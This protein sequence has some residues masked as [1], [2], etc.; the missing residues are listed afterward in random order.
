MNEKMKRNLIIAAIAAG[1]LMITYISLLL[2]DVKKNHNDSLII[3]SIPSSSI[4]KLEFRGRDGKVTLIKKGNKWVYEQD[5]SFPLNENFVYSMI[6]KTSLLKA[7]R[8]V[9]EGKKQF[10]VYGLDKPSNIIQVTAGEQKKTIYL[11]DSNSAT[12]DYYLAVADSDKIYTV[13]SVL[14]NLFSSSLYDMAIRETLPGFNL[15]NIQCFSVIDELGTICFMRRATTD[16]TKNNVSS[17]SVSRNG[18][19]AQV[20]DDRL[21]SELL[22]QIIKMRFEAMKVYKPSANQ[23]VSY[24]LEEPQAILKVDFIHDSSSQLETY[25][26]AVGHLTDEGS[27]YYVQPKNGAAI[28]I[29]NAEKV[30]PFL[31]L[32]SEDF[33][34]LSVAA[35]K[36]DTLRGLRL[37]TKDGEDIFTINRSEE[38]RKIIF[39]LNGHDISEASFNSFYYHLYGLTAEKRVS[40]VSQQLKEPAEVTI[41]FERKE[42]PDVTVKL[43]PYD[44]NY[45]CASVDS[46]A[47]LLIN[48]QRV[49][50]LLNNIAKL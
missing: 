39:Q 48:R 35:I 8:F 24:G 23:L 33:L 29:M 14:V 50:N 15:R 30:K 2:L 18:E 32:N 37:I 49:K 45:Y 17:W 4:S 9:D 1:L 5:E 26:L 41:I 3:Y 47:V 11:G 44:Y 25:T 46:E 19:T 42:A 38:N 34:P 28:Y 21:V 13:D 31:H 36:P 40:D 43:Y 22:S 6:E 20:A 12:G 7:K 16:F 10:K 27:H